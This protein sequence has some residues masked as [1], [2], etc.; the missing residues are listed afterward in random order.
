MKVDEVEINLGKDVQNDVTADEGTDPHQNN[1]INEVLMNPIKKVKRSYSVNI[2]D[3]DQKVVERGFIT[4]YFDCGLHYAID[5]AIA[6]HKSK[7]SKINTAFKDLNT[8]LK[9]ICHAKMED[10][11]SDV[12]H[13]LYK[14]PVWPHVYEKPDISSPEW[15]KWSKSREDIADSIV[16]RLQAAYMGKTTFTGTI[17]AIYNKLNKKG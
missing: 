14:T 10:K 4:E 8:K 9:Q 3:T 11:P 5:P 16:K 17:S 2:L 6:M 7:P 15:A 12:T 1:N 13:P